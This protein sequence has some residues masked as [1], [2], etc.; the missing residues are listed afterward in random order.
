MCGLRAL[1]GTDTLPHAARG[2]TAA[3]LLDL[4]L[5]AGSGTPAPPHPPPPPS[6]QQQDTNRR[7]GPRR[8]AHL[9]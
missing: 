4:P 2:G 3:S 1:K 6:G 7:G 8:A 5:P 9:S